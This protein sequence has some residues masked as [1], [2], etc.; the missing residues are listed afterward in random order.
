[1]SRKAAAVTI[2]TAAALAVIIGLTMQATAYAIADS[3][4]AVVVGFALTAAGFVTF[5]ANAPL[6]LGVVRTAAHDG[7]YLTLLADQEHNR[8]VAR[9]TTA[10]VLPLER[11]SQ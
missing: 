10:P 1:M 8:A 2:V 7:A 4:P 6:I 3:G 11:R 5:A 9:S